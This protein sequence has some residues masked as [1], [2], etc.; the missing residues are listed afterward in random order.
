M[1]M[2]TRAARAVERARA[3]TKVKAKYILGTGNYNPTRPDDPFTEKDGKKGCDCTGFTAY[4]LKLYRR[5]SKALYPE[6]GGYMNTDSLVTHALASSRPGRMWKVIPVNEAQP[7]DILVYDAGKKTGHAAL[8]VEVPPMP[9]FPPGSAAEKKALFKL[10]RVIDCAN[11][12]TRRIK[13]YAI[14]ERDGSLWCRPDGYVL[15]YIGGDA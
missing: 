7:G 1:T 13:G 8:I 5:Q 6:T 9:V 10:L 15:R 4:C 2:T 3:A 14:A 12:L 11:A